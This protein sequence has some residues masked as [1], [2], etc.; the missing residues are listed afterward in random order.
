VQLPSPPRPARRARFRPRRLLRRPIP[1]WVAAVLLAAVTTVTVGRVTGEA[2]A[3]RARWG[4]ERPVVV[5]LADHDPGDALRAEV[6]LLPA[7]VVPDGALDELPAR[8]T[9]VTALAA[10]EVVVA[11]RIAPEGLSLVAAR[12]PSE[13]RGVAVPHGIAP[14][15]V[16][17]GDRADVLASFETETI[18]VATGALVVDVGEDAVTIAVDEDDAAGVAYAVTAGV[19]TLALS[20]TSWRR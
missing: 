18:T 15:P 12:L 2:A 20:G 19:V 1:W 16:E 13:T 14:L 8:A 7:A 11:R 6:R 4:H 10:G 17:V 9:A 5:A 3:E